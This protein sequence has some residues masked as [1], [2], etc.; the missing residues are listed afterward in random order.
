[1]GDSHSIFGRVLEQ[2]NVPQHQ[3][4]EMCLGYTKTI[5]LIT[6]LF[7]GGLLVPQILGLLAAVPLRAYS[8]YHGYLLIRN[9]PR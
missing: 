5:K 9:N 8:S 7:I 6:S 4:S 3:A 1:M 2:V